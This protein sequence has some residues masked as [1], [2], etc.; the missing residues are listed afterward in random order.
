MEISMELVITSYPNSRNNNCFVWGV[1]QPDSLS[2]H[3]N[4]LSPNVEFKELPE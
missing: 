4:F 2:F 3:L 1:S